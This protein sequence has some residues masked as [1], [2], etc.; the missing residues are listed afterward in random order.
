MR[1]VIIVKSLSDL[2]EEELVVADRV[3]AVLPEHIDRDCR[4]NRDDAGK[5]GHAAVGEGKDI[6]RRQP[7][8]RT[9]RLDKEIMQWPWG[10]CGRRWERRKQICLY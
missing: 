2:P 9:S 10:C 5:G 7:G 1:V 4:W 3:V 6:V 8:A